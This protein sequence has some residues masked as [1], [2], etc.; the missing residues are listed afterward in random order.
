MARG[1]YSAARAHLEV[2]L[3]A[4]RRLGDEMAEAILLVALAG[5]ANEEGNAEAAQTLVNQ[6]LPTLR[7]QGGKR[8]IAMG[9]QVLGDVAAQRRNFAEARRLLEESLSTWKQVCGLTGSARVILD[10]GR[11]ASEEGNNDLA[12]SQFAEGLTRCRDIGDR[13]GAALGLE[14]LATMAVRA[15]R[16]EDAV[17]LA[18]AAAA[19]REAAHATLSPRQAVWLKDD[20]ARARRALA[21][22]TYAAAWE[23]GRALPFE[24]AI[25]LALRISDTGLPGRMT[26]REREVVSLVARGCTDRQI[27]EVLIIDKRTA[28]WHVS[29]IL[30]KLGLSSR[31]QIAIWAVDHG[32]RVRQLPDD[33]LAIH[34][35]HNQ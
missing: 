5:V 6:A 13:W 35:R 28:E 31:A 27:A 9:L 11:L 14:G 34:P 17:H 18:G 29:K 10:L 2:G 8:M 33:A 1:D 20:L 4:S 21:G 26:R 25:Q 12:A 15:G 24:Q 30:G 19:L 7:S 32:L 23:A 22:A 16:P 3:V